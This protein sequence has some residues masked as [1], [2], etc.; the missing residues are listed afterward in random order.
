MKDRRSL[1]GRPARTA[2]GAGLIGVALAP[3]APVA[4]A[5]AGPNLWNPS[6]LCQAAPNR[7][8]SADA[9]AADQE[10]LSAPSFVGDG[11]IFAFAPVGNGVNRLALGAQAREDSVL[12]R[13]IFL[14]FYRPLPGPWRLSPPRRPIEAYQGTDFL[15]FDLPDAGGT[16][17]ISL[18]GFVTLETIVAPAIY[19]IDAPIKPQRAIEMKW[20][21]GKCDAAGGSSAC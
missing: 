1:F 8:A 11:N 17:V 18:T 2:C 19:G 6:E 13:A 16:A 12:G 10:I 5:G 20:P 9:C 4:L 15:T 3:W 7:P 14:G 21:S